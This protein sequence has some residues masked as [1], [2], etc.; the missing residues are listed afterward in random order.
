M[1]LSAG[2][3][4]LL[5]DGGKEIRVT[6][7]GQS[8]AQGSSSL[9]ASEWIILPRHGADP[10]RLT[11]QKNCGVVDG[12][13]QCEAGGPSV[14]VKEVSRRQSVIGKKAVERA[15]KTHAAGLAERIHLSAGVATE[16][17]IR[18]RGDYLKFLQRFD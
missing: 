1:R 6:C 14:L 7:R 17:R 15:V 5:F 11:V 4:Y 8:A 16:P 2:V 9:R 12:A 10:Q 3:N 13:R 18:Q